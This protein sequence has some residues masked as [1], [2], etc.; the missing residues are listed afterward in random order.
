MVTVGVGVAAECHR[1]GTGN[2][3][4]PSFFRNEVHPG[5]EARFGFET[6]GSVDLKFMVKVQRQQ[7]QLA[8]SEHEYRYS[9][10]AS[11][12]RGRYIFLFAPPTGGTYDI[13][14]CT[15]VWL[16]SS[17]HFSHVK[18]FSTDALDKLST[19]DKFPSFLELR[20]S[21]AAGAATAGYPALS[22]VV[23]GREVNLCGPSAYTMKLST[24][25]TTFCFFSPRKTQFMGTVRT[26]GNR[27]ID[28]AALV[29]L[30]DGVREGEYMYRVRYVARTTETCTLTIG[31]ACAL[32][33][34]ICTDSG[35][36][37]CRRRI[38]RRF[39]AAYCFAHSV[40]MFARR[41]AMGAST[42][43]HFS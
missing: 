37:S 36:S 24:P 40:R 1:R 3:L 23:L 15:C 32:R 35:G 14:L 30:E 42:S 38:T 12:S 17:R 10:V 18:D 26:D 20:C 33:Y 43:L 6:A 16:L 8:Y 29:Q 28:H 11:E 2:S 13:E 39:T 4:S 22:G 19:N 21:I 9:F 31:I 27:L 25:Y 34:F 5:P 7:Q 41:R